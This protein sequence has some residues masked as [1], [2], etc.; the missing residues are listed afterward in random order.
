MVGI[1]LCIGPIYEFTETEIQTISQGW[2]TI[3]LCDGQTAPFCNNQEP[4]NSRK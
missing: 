3:S 4:E 2:E 1:F